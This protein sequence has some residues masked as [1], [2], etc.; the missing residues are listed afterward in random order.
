[1]ALLARYVVDRL[2][3][4][5]VIGLTGSCGKT[6]TK[7][8]IAQLVSRRRPDG[9][10]GRFVQQRARPP[11]H[12]AAGRPRRP[13]SWSSSWARAAA[14]TCATCARSRRRGSASCSTSA[15]RTSASSARSRRSREAKGELVESLPT[16]GVAVLNADDPRVR[17][18]ASRTAA[19]VVYV[20]EAADATVRA[21]DVS[22][23]AAGRMAYTLV[24]PAGSARSSW[25]CRDGIR[26]ATRS[27]RRPSRSPP[28]VPFDEVATGLGELRLVSTRRMDVFDRADGDHGHRRLVQREPGLDVGRAARAGATRPGPAPDRGA[29]LPGR[30][31]RARDGPDIDEVGELAAKLDVDRLIVVGDAARPIH[32]GATRC[33]VGA[34]RDGR[35]RPGGRR[36]GAPRCSC[37]RATSS[38]SRGRATGP[39]TVVDALREPRLVRAPGSDG[40]A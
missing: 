39:G 40:R 11:V 15:C 36:R 9:G 18:M 23:D 3:A 22:V 5:T 26:S 31:R 14:A 13:A 20:G 30:A 4:T 19:S 34:E 29:R 10:P 7:D 37:A 17:A 1:M 2:P 35:R 21:E 33:P 38:W 16:D 6:T 27:P 28:A 24:T 12:G 8:F 25:P 32:D